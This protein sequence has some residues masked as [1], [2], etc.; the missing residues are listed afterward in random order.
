MYCGKSKINKKVAFI[1]AAAGLGKRMGLDYPKQFLEYKGEPLFYSSLKIAFE[2]K[3]IDEI[4]IITNEENLEY[5][6][7]FCKEKELFSKVKKIVKGGAERQESVY[8]ALREI[9]NADCVI[10]QDGV[11]PF[12]KDEYIEKT[13]EVVD[14][15]YDGAVIGVK[16]KDTVKLVDIDNEIISTPARDFIILVHTPQTFKFDIIK[17]AHEEAKQRKI[18]ATDDSMLVE[19]MDNKRIKFIHGDYDNI[20]ITTKEDLKFLK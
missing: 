1:L 14:D 8:N 6:N 7:K 11:R 9:K 3:L 13:L 4:Y 15:G 17:Q 19:R 12:L 10:I 18:K 16:V 20:K 5:M 2:N